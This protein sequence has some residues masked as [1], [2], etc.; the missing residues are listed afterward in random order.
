MKKA[1]RVVLSIALAAL[2][3]LCGCGK[4]D[5]DKMVEKYDVPLSGCAVVIHF[6]R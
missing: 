4:I 3:A 5:F 1:K 6:R 2:M